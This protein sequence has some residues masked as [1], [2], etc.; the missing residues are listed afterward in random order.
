MTGRGFAKEVERLCFAVRVA[1]SKPVEVL[2]VSFAPAKAPADWSVS[3]TIDDVGETEVA[4]AR[5]A[6]RRFRE[7]GR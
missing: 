1:R 7:G 2:S 4:R 3:V 6:N 5:N